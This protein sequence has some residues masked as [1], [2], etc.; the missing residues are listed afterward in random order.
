MTNFTSQVEI[1]KGK[2]KPRSFSTENYNNKLKRKGSPLKLH[3]RN[4]CYSNQKS[5]REKRQEGG[6]L[7]VMVFVWPFTAKINPKTEEHPKNDLKYNFL[8]YKIKI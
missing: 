1:Q 6:I 4:N 5:Q 2:K 8:K 7:W 3:Q